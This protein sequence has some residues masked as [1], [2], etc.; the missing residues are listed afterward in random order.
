MSSEASEQELTAKPSEE[1]T[2]AQK[3]KAKAKTPQAKHPAAEA[4]AEGGEKKKAPKS[5]AEAPARV[6]AAEAAVEAAPEGGEKK[7]APRPKAEAPAR[8]KA[9][10]AAVEAPQKPLGPSRLKLK[11]QGLI[12][13]LV[14][15][16][17]YRN[18]MEVPRV[19][20]IV[21]NIGLGQAVQDP[22]MLE[23]AEKDLTI[24]SGQHPVITRAK[25]SIAA[26][27]LRA[28]MPIGI[29]VTMRGRRMYD[30]FDRLVSVVLP[31]I[32]DFSGV[33][34]NAFDSRGN[35]NIGLKE[36]LVFPEIEFDKV[37]KIRGMQVSIV[38]TARNARE[39]KR[40]LELLG[41]PFKREGENG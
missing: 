11:Y 30:F 27:K 23:G 4:A 1:A 12:P 8:A 18:V 10:E 15:E 31:R 3:P 39:G 24:I 26:F 9:A 2:G 33:S 36:Q 19:V 29:M 14:K 25:K 6:K 22:K 20:K 38:T 41:V 7:K 40:L 34:G 16:F 17:G 13:Q 5:K 32:R 21:L 37:D 35:Y 28:G